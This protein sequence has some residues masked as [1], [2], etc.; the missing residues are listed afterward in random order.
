VIAKMFARLTGGRPMTKEIYAFRD[1]VR[2]E[3]VFIWRDFFGRY[4]MAKTRWGWFRCQSE[5]TRPELWR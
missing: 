1:V 2:N 5:N 3:P 4:W